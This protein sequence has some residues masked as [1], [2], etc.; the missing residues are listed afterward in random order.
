MNLPAFV[1]A[2][3]GR[4]ALCGAALLFAAC[5]GPEP[6]AP[7]PSSPFQLDLDDTPS[8]ESIER[9]RSVERT[10]LGRL[11]EAARFRQPDEDVFVELSSINVDPHSGR[12]FATDYNTAHVYDLTHDLSI[13]IRLVAGKGDGPGEMQNPG[14]PSV[15]DAGRF[16]IPDL[17][18][19]TLE[20]FDANGE[21]LR[22]VALGVQ[23]FRIGIE[24]ESLFVFA[25][26]EGGMFVEYRIEDLLAPGEAAPIRQFGDFKEGFAPGRFMLMSGSV[27]F[28]DGR[29]YYVPSF[30]PTFYVVDLK[31]ETMRIYP[32]IDF[33]AF[34][35]TEQEE[36][37]VETGESGM[38]VMRPPDKRASRLSFVSGDTLF[39]ASSFTRT[40]ERTF[41]DAYLVGSGAYVGSIELKGAVRS[42]SG[43][44]TSLLMS[45][46]EGDVL[47][48]DRLSAPD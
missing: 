45:M 6:E 9:I 24:D 38:A 15:D 29:L 8:A 27:A 41:L 1:Q 10:A 26:T 21:H 18:G 7:A 3:L 42:V 44:A 36:P 32:T 35:Q 47:R 46:R 30:I 14:P 16:H 13:R 12:W 37:E 40:E 4:G 39:L 23:P 31:T 5:G 2:R 17:Y 28:A 33:L 19:R 22:S 11:R 43:D 34:D 48:F 20:I 25:P